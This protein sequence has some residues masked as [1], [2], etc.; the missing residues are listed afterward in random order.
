VWINFHDRDVAMK[1]DSLAQLLDD[2]GGTKVRYF[3][4]AEYAAYLHAEVERTAGGGDLPA[5]RVRYTA[6]GCA[7]FKD[8]AS[9]WTL[10]LSDDVQ[11][12]LTPAAPEKR[13]VEVAA[14]LGTHTIQR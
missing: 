6:P 8:H 11:S 3:T 1:P 5:L 10:H 14:G 13:V 4:Y 9:R 2:I 7:F 12:G